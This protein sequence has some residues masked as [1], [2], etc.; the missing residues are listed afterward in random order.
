MIAAENMLMIGATGRNS[1]KTELASQI[2]RAFQNNFKIIGLKVSTYYEDDSAFHS[3]QDFLKENFTIIKDF[4]QTGNKSTS[5]ML[6]AG[7]SDVY[8]INT[9]IGYMETAYQEFIHQIDKKAVI[10]CESNSL[11]KIV[12]PGLFI[13]IR[14]TSNNTIKSTASDVIGFTDKE[15]LFNG[16]RFENF[17]ISDLSFSNGKWSLKERD[18]DQF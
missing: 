12:T 1:G 11:R 5:R 3:Q 14:N 13:M 7:A 2:I 16:S 9:K 8:W 15:I 18:D 10:V 6:S 4:D 17:H